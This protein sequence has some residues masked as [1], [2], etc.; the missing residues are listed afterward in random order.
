MI[1]TI[2][3]KSLRARLGRTIFI[4][5]AIMLGVSFV[6]GSFVLADSLRATFDSLF[7][8]LNEDVDFEVRSVLEVDDPQ[9][10]R[11][12]VP[13]SLVDD[14]A[15]IDGI[16]QVEPF[17]LRYAQMLD[18]EGEPIRTQGAPAIGASWSGESA[19]GGIVIREGR[20]PNG[21]DEVAIDVAT[22]NRVNYRVG[23]PLTVITD[24]GQFDFTIVG[25]V[26]LGDADGFGGATVSVFDT[27][28]SQV[29]LDSQGTFD[30]I[31]I[32]LAEGADPATVRADIERV[33]PERVEVV[34]GEQVAQEASDQVGTFIN[35]FGTGL[36]IFAVITAF[37][38]GFIIN[39]VFSIT[40]TQRLRELALLRAIGANGTQVRSMIIVEALLVSVTATILGI[41]G[42][43][44]V[45]RG[46]IAIFDAAGAGFP[47]R[48]W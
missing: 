13:A 43:L 39:N 26:G 45:A 6:A 36:L 2:T 35:A 8:G 21:L 30:A 40:I 48:R 32:A 44:G 29:I 31:D 20:A 25:L 15:A 7:K 27:E 1:F 11:D 34:T 17:V 10:Q 18:R 12:P 3:R 24:A 47:P 16:Q 19:I 23:D 28:S 4:G 9:A 38:A 5:L 33:L 14:L 22:A 37:V 41:F 42:G 46:L